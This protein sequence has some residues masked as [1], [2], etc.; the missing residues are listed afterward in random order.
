[1]TLFGT[2]AHDL[3]LAMVFY[4][5]SA[6]AVATVFWTVFVDK[7]FE[8]TRSIPKRPS[9]GPRQEYRRR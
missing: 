1:M 7:A 5:C 2:N 6:L 3:T 8:R 4:G 9:S